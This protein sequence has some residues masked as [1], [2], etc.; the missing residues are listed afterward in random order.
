VAQS[1]QRVGE[2]V[3]TVPE[4]KSGNVFEQALEEHRELREKLAGLRGVLDQPRP[5]AGGQAAQSWAAGLSS[6]LVELH[7]ML[8]G[9]FREEE[10]QGVLDKLAQKHPGSARQI[11][12]LKGQH[13]QVLDGIRELT[14]AT[15][16]YSA[17]TETAD[18]RL[19][20]RLGKLLDSI[21]S[22]EH[23]ETDLIQRL[24]Y[25]DLGEGD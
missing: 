10:E 6:R 20:K 1:L 18:P 3:E 15:L 21:D 17:G 4:P 14:A 19:R 2:E 11:I 22:H 16:D 23:V 9:H 25:Q 5:E 12:A 24:E 8:T 13:Q 7:A